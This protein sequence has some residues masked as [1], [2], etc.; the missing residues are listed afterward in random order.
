MRFALKFNGNTVIQPTESFNKLIHPEFYDVQAFILNTGY[1]SLERMIL[2]RSGS[3][4][5][6]H[7]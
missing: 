3:G 7:V 5:Q 6:T 1:G 2:E 4:T